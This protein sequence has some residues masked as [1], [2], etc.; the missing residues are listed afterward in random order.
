EPLFGQVDALNLERGLKI[1]S[2][3]LAEKGLSPAEL[4]S[5]ARSVG[6]AAALL[7]RQG[8]RYVDKG[9]QYAAPSDTRAEA[10][11]LEDPLLLKTPVVR[12]ASAATVGY[13]PD[14]WE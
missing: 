6:G 8:R 9:L 7:D 12:R 1:Q 10:L 5:V 11:L 13:S 4:K 2:I 14:V 3:D